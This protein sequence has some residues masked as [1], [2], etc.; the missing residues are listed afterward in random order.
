MTERK[1]TGTEIIDVTIIGG[2]PAG[3][4]AAIELKRLGVE[5]IVVLE[6]E[7]EAGGIPR[8]CGHPPFGMREF[9]RLLTGPKYAEKLVA[10]ARNAGVELLTSTTVIE[11]RADANLLIASDKGV[12]EISPRRII[13]ATGVR[14]TPR[15]ARLISG[16]RPLGILN[17]GA[18]QS[19]IYLKNRKPFQR[20]VIIGSE[21]VSFSA[22]MTC[23]HAGIKPVAMIEQAAHVTARWPSG[24][25]P[26]ITGIPLHLS[27]R[28][29][30]IRGKDR[31]SAVDIINHQGFQQT[32]DCDGVILTGCFTPETAL[33][34]T[35]HIK[36]DPETGGPEVDQY[37]R[38]SDPRYF[39]TGNILRPV[40]TAGWC[41]NEGRQTARWV[42]DDLMG[43]LP[44][45]TSNMTIIST[46]PAIKYAMPQRLALPLGTSTSSGM[47]NLQLRVLH[48]V[49]GNLLALRNGNIVWKKRLNTS[50]ERRI[51][52][53][54]DQ[55]IDAGMQGNIEL[56][57]EQC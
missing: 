4:S 56:K 7:T 36:V 48:Q 40:E 23:R 45:P 34:R 2:G 10:T 13:Y 28:L 52:V 20:P 49:K 33:A 11:A 39:A 1:V 55:L 16:A 8:H 24:L 12:E 43:K 9:K 44:G 47:K 35:G 32:I 3:L 21:L 31:V 50:A 30:G 26:V 57:F 6:R 14:E 41:W 53:P 42:A 15:S 51:L 27:T 38:C 18:L 54:V 5:R 19:M 37:G 25:F 46:G 22:I 17:T 29:L